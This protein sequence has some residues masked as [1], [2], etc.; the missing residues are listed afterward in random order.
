MEPTA[1]DVH[2]T[3]A[4]IDCRA[5][6]VVLYYGQAKFNNHLEDTLDF[7]VRQSNSTEEGLRRVSRNLTRA[8]EINIDNLFTLSDADKAEIGNLNRQLNS[9]ANT[10]ERDTADNA[11]DIKHYIN[12]V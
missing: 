4:L 10:L 1:I 8:A 9:S 6:C 12:I 2:L 7:I 3:R 11:R 5:G